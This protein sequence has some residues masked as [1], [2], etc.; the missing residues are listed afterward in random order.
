MNVRTIRR[1]GYTILSRHFWLG[2][3]VGFF[4]ASFLST[5]IANAQVVYVPNPNVA[6][7]TPANCGTATTSNA[8]A[9]VTIASTSIPVGGVLKTFSF[10]T[11]NGTTHYKA[12]L[13]GT[14][15]PLEV[16]STTY[17][18]NRFSGGWLTTYF[19]YNTPIT[20]DIVLQLEKTT[21]SA[22]DGLR[23]Q[24]SPA[25]GIT[26]TT[27]NGCSNN[28]MVATAVFST[29][30]I[31]SSGS[32]STVFYPLGLNAIIDDMN[33]VNSSTGTDCTFVY[34]NGVQF[35][36]DLFL[37]IFIIFFATASMTFW[38]VQRFFKKISS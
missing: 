16:A 31:P 35:S 30:T 8:I 37:F 24:A 15:T 33:C 11:A 3:G 5:S 4:I 9:T 34:D 2:L 18:A 22:L 19:D 27:V 26:V 25:T 32:T 20:S 38:V 28:T 29:S 7:T 10:Q 17:G 13:G 6:A 36:T 12:Y 23:K 14:T 21:I 1:I